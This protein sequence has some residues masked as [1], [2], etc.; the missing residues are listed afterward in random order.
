ML[1]E[2]SKQ[3]ILQFL[4]LKSSSEQIFSKNCRWLQIIQMRREKEVAIVYFKYI[5]T[6]VS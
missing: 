4:D 3:E 1:G 5:D 2:A 6:C